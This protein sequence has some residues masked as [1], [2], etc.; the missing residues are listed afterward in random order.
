MSTAEKIGLFPGFGWIAGH[1]LWVTLLICWFI[2]PGMIFILGW[3]GESRMIPVSPN[4]QFISFIPGDFFLGAMAASILVL[5]QDLPSASNWYNSPWLHG[6]VVIAAVSVAVLLTRG[7]YQDPNGYG[8]RGV[9]SP[10][11][12]YHNL[13]LYGGYGYVIITTLVA[14]VSASETRGWF[15]AGSLVFGVIWVSLLVLE[16]RDSEKVKRQRVE[17]AHV[18][19]WSPIWR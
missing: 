12:L 17:N 15:L 16:R 5:A 2:T 13:V 14:V 9:L 10:T 6:A 7:E 18:S 8:R 3:I 1:E 19:N 11:K 4:Y